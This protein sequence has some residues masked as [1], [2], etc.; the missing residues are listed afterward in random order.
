MPIKKYFLLVLPFFLLAVGC[1]DKKKSTPVLSKKNMSYF[2]HTG[3]GEKNNINVSYH[4]DQV[5]LDSEQVEVSTEIALPPNFKGKVYFKWMLAEGVKLAEGSL[6]GNFDDKLISGDTKKISIK[7]TGFSKEA[8][9][10]I[11]FEV[12]GSD[13]GQSLSTRILLASDRQNTFEDIVQHVEKI[14]A[15]E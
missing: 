14:K 3:R 11:S 8:N 5:A 7:V 9:H 10:H 6:S 15:E 2:E 12:Y 13:R 4:F 1:F